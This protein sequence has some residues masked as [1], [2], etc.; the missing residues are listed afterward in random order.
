MPPSLIDTH[1]AHTHIAHSSYPYPHTVSSMLKLTA[2]QM[3]LPD[4]QDHLLARLLG[5]KYDGDEH[6]F[7]NEELCH[8]HQG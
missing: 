3:F 8:G 5:I 4:L 7:T 6:A 1:T 2:Y